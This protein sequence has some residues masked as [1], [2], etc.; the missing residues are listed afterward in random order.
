MGVGK[1]PRLVTVEWRDILGTSGW[2]KP[3]EVD[4]PTF[5]TV[6]YL[7]KK[8]KEVIKIA[9]TKDEK[10]EWTTITA[11]PAGCVKK[12]TNIAS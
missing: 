2:E 10:G 1:K 3:S 11:F 8:N 5:W 9:S 4:P 7:I 6:G 12:I